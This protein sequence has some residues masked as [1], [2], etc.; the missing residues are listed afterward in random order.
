MIEG[1]E[2]LPTTT[3]NGKNLYPGGHFLAYDLAT[4]EFEDLAIAPEGEGILT[5]TIDRERGH[6]YGITWPLGYFIHYDISAKTLKKSVWFRPT[7]KPNSVKITA[8]CAVRWWLT[9]AT[10][11]FIFLLP[12]AIFLRIILIKKAYKK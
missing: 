12:K 11:R 2:R 1:M 3:P 5:M 9:H 8:Y 7:A 6:L 10:R 4:G